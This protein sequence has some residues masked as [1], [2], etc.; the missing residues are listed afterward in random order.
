MRRP[1]NKLSD[2]EIVERDRK[3]K[4][5]NKQKSLMV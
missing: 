3:L 4:S 1:I 5:F 2:D